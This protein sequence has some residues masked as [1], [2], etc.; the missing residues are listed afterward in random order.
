MVFV[1]FKKTGELKR[2]VWN[3]V[4][5]E[6]IWDGDDGYEFDYEVED[7]IVR[8]E[9]ARLIEENFGIKATKISYFLDETDGWD[10]AIDYYHDELHEIFKSEAMEFYND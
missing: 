10:S 1:Y 9:T 7:Y 4:D 3:G 2:T 5:Y 6:D 8:R